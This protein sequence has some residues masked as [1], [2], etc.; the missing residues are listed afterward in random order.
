MLSTPGEI[1]D[2]QLEANTP[3]LSGTLTCP[4]SRSIFYVRN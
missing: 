2:V 1:D 3:D 4:R